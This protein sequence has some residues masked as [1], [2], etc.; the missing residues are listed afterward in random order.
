MTH[1]DDHDLAQPAGK[2]RLPPHRIG[3]IEPARGERR[4]VKQHA[5]NIDQLPAPPGAKFFDH[6]RELGM[7]LFLDEGH[8]RHDVPLPSATREWLPAARRSLLHLEPR[9]LY[10]R[11]PTRELFGDELACRL[12]SRIGDR[13]E[14]GGHQDALNVRV[15]HD[16]AR[17]IGEPLDIGSAT[18]A[19]ANSPLRLPAIMPGNPASTAVGSVGNAARRL[20]LVTQSIRTFPVS[21]NSIMWPVTL[22]AIIGM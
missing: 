1:A 10:Y 20:G 7:L 17:G 6:L 8:A 14:P 4:R 11:G 13:F 18:P 3:V 21:C 12:G 9:C 15:R 22:C 2:G 5:I 19:G 16:L